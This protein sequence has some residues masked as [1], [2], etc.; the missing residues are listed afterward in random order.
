MCIRD[1]VC[2][3]FN[4]YE[5]WKVCVVGSEKKRKYKKGLKTVRPWWI[6]LAK[7]TTTEPTERRENAR[8]KV[9]LEAEIYKQIGGLAGK[10]STLTYSKCNVWNE[11][12]DNEL[13][14]TSCTHVIKSTVNSSQVE[15]SLWH[16]FPGF[17]WPL[18]MTIYPVQSP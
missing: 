9:S 15:K 6:H 17:F 4:F 12:Y 16:T 3:K 11:N 8:R 7:L 10:L 14:N 18:R 13:R 1:S 5:G 2:P